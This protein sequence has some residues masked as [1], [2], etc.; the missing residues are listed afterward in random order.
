[1]VNFKFESVS[2]NRPMDNVNNPFVS[3]VCG[4]ILVLESA[5]HLD[6]SICLFN[7]GK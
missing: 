7:K 4:S 1:M 6:I 5:I 2:F 3:G